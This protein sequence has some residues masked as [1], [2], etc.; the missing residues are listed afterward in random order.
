MVIIIII[1]QMRG[2][3]RSGHEAT[4][5]PIFFK[6][7]KILCMSLHEYTWTSIQYVTMNTVIISY[8]HI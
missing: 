1:K 7:T 6:N 2:H 3:W 5:S 8:G 4:S